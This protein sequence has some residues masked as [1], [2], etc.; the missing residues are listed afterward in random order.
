VK[1][2][3]GAVERKLEFNVTQAKPQTNPSS[4]KLTFAPNGMTTSIA[5][6]TVCRD[7]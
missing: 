5:K 1:P 6:I 3:G 4:L 7:D 2:Q